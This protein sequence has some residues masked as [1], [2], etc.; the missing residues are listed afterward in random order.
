M[1]TAYSSKRIGKTILVAG[2]VAGTLDIIA[3]LVNGYIQRANKDDSFTDVAARILKYIAGGVF[4]LKKSMVGGEGMIIAGLLFHY[5]IA[6]SLTAFF[7]FL[8]VKWKALSNLAVLIP[9]GIL[10]GLFAWII[11]TKVIIPYISALPKAK[12]AFEWGN[13][14][15]WWQAR[16]AILILMFAIGLPIALI[17]HAYLKRR[18]TV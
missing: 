15:H 11:T 17:T 8:Y 16:V 9:F 7:V 14:D 13:W 1:T 3:A 18:K 2:A 10:Y 4:T 12:V 5:I 6:F